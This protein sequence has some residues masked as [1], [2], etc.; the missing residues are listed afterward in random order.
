MA[1]NHFQLAIVW[2]LLTSS[3]ALGFPADA[4]AQ[5]NQTLSVAGIFGDG[6]V[7][8]RESDAAIWGW[9]KPDAEVRIKAS[10]Q[11]QATEVTADADGK[12]KTTINTPAAGGPFTLA[13][14]SGEQ[15]KAFKNIL[16]GEVWICSGQS[17]MQWKLRGFGVDYFKEDVQK[18]NHPNIR[19]CEVPR[20]IALQP[21]DDQK[22][23]WQTCTPKTALNFSAVAY[24]FGD[25]LREEL[26]VPIGLISTGWGGSTAEAWMNPDVVK[27]QFPHLK[28]VING[29][30]DLIKKYGV[31][32]TDNKKVLKEAKGVTQK[33]PAVL[34]NGM[35]R[36]I[37]PFSCRGVIWYQGEAN[38]E[39]PLQYRKLFPSLIKN[40]RQDWGKADLPFYYVQLA[41]FRYRSEPL[42]IAL[43]RE[44]QFQTL[45][46]P[47]TAMVVTM[48]VGNPNS[49][50]PK[51]KKPVG[52]RLALVALAKD[53]G[54]SAI[55]YSGPE[56]TDFE[57]E[58]NQVRLRFK[59]VGDGLASRDGKPLSHFTI[60]GKDKQFYPATAQIDGQTIL[61]Q[62][63]KVNQPVAVRFAWGNADEPNLMNKEGLP[64]SSFRTDN[65]KVGPN[66]PNKPRKQTKPDGASAP[67]SKAQLSSPAAKGLSQIPINVFGYTLL[68]KENAPDSFDAGFSMYPTLWSLVE[69]HPGKKYQSGL[70]G[71]WM[72]IKTE[73]PM[74]GK[75]G[76]E[77][78]GG[79]GYNT[80]EGGSGVWRHNRFPTVTPKFQMGGVAL[81]FKGIA[82]GPGFGKGKDWNVDQGRYGVAQLSNRVVFPLDGLNYKQGTFGQSFGYGYL[83]LP[84]TPAKNKTAGKDVPTGNQS[85]TL[86][87]NSK[88]FKGPLTFFTPY[89][90]SRHTIDYPHLHG[91]LFDSRP[92][93]TNRPI[94]MET[95]HISAIQAESKSGDTYA[96][97]TRIRFPLAKDGTSPVFT[98]NTCYDKSALWDDVDAWFKG[99]PIATGQIKESGAFKTKVL[100]GN[101]NT[102]S[103]NRLKDGQKIKRR[104]QWNSFVERAQSDDY[105]FA[106]RFDSEKTQHDL[107]NGLV[108]LPEYYKLVAKKD[109]STWV[110][111]AKEDV[112][113][114]TGLQNLTAADFHTGKNN[115]QP[116]T[117]PDDPAS[118]WKTPGPAAG[119]FTT[120]LGDGST[121]TYYWYKFNE[122]P[123]IMKADLSDRE[124]ADLQKK[125]ELIHTHWTPDKEYLP[126]PANR[127]L[128]ELDPAII[129]TPPAGMEIGYVPIA[130]RQ[131]ME[132]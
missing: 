100:D 61:V 72:S 24:F 40:W 28:N 27:E 59:H 76:A 81:S 5:E 46:V 2:A 1:M 43:L 47:N 94:Q 60:A 127:E 67:R 115:D 48:D 77:K 23:R 21:Q 39:R 36:P 110:P 80:V 92:N 49:I 13:V 22:L 131:A 45:A 114:E 130:S 44:A 101:Q 129:V 85:W 41:P 132:Q 128:A 26:D 69:T 117:T 126:T 34:Y 16:S 12:W 90:W 38:V 106:L 107:E 87:I 78:D 57:I 9:A 53:Y 3:A 116:W 55:V 20:Q 29:Y 7:L 56:Y 120:K 8:Q 31:S 84:L 79:L 96:R 17:N 112:P 51:R 105:T 62:S 70:F 11:D 124:R 6:M 118:V 97:T 71:T 122:Q 113:P 37:I 54:R 50:H 86:F 102:W 68:P 93:R 125:I 108:T 121:L 119:P 18:A 4:A 25:K 103:F 52:E 95:Q 89:F 58:T 30:D 15:K 32:F 42:P 73:Q 10:W 65:W 99:G 111:I 63:A 88:T 75:I 98:C 82:N 109:K 66:K 19:Y 35:L 83:P 14:E 104:I 123:S 33:I 91:K 64:S 74:S